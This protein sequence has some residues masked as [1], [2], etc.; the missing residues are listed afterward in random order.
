M[1]VFKVICNTLCSIL[2]GALII[3][4]GLL[5]V[6][7]FIGYEQYVV[8]SGS[9]EPNIHV[10]AIAYDKPVAFADVEAGDIITYRL[11]GD[12]LV[13][14]RVLR[15]QDDTLIMKGDA[16]ETEDAAPVTSNQVVGKCYF[17]IPYIGYVS[18]YIRTGLGIGMAC[19]I[20]IFIILISS[21]PDIFK[22]DENKKK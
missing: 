17:S 10:G 14:H 22:P 15:T 6:P 21:L 5:I 7:K 11:D 20:L 1:K 8:M 18:M 16:N 13:T 9:M 19:G 4:A 2:I 12:V 3:I